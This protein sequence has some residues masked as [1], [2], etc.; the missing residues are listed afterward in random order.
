[1]H[2]VAF[3]DILYKCEDIP[4]FWFPFYTGQFETEKFPSSFSEMAAF[5]GSKINGNFSWGWSSRSEPDVPEVQKQKL[6]L[7]NM[8]PG[9]EKEELKKRMEK[10]TDF[11]PELE[12]QA[13]KAD[14]TDWLKGTSKWNTLPKNERACEVMDIWFQKDGHPLGEPDPERMFD[15]NKKVRVEHTPWEKNTLVH[16]PGVHDFLRGEYNNRVDYEKRKSQLWY[17]GPQNIDDAWL[18]YKWFVRGM[19]PNEW[20]A[21]NDDKDAW[22]KQR[23]TAK[24]NQ[25]RGYARMNDSQIQWVPD[26]RPQSLPAADPQ[27][28][29]TATQV[30][31][32]QSTMGTTMEAVQTVSDA[33]SQ[34]VEEVQ[35]REVADASGSTYSPLPPSPPSYVDF[36]P[37]SLARP[38]VPGILARGVTGAARGG[39]PINTP[40]RDIRAM[41]R[42]SE[43]PT[44]M[45]PLR[46]PQDRG[47]LDLRGAQRN[48]KG[49]LSTRAA[50]E[51]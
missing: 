49:P 25:N 42:L 43:D 31:P 15:M 48:L 36:V 32:S 50:S 11:L 47:N 6:A 18:Y 22:Y 14:F 46:Q 5:G 44:T 34:T 30:A 37:G 10:V 19:K 17:H 24:C 3:F 39:T 4:C 28:R 33:G 35:V 41:T 1:M 20:T 23:M 9:P 38:D 29:D 51:M 13:L 40:R 2:L 16:L 26:N 7:D 8:E 21:H 45:A 12:D 27:Y